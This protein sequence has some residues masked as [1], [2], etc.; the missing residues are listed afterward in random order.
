MWT[1]GQNDYQIFIL[2]MFCEMSISNNNMLIV[3][4]TGS[5][6][7]EINYDILLSRFLYLKLAL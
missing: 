5:H 4:I 6:Y 1:I 3:L 7:T 2:T